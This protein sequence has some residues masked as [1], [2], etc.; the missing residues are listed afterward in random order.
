MRA[1]AIAENR[2]LKL[3]Q[4]RELPLEAG[5]VRVEVSYCGICGSDLHMLHLPGMPVGAI[6]GHEASGRVAEVGSD[7]HDWNVG[8][9]VVLFPYSPCGSC[10][11]CTA[12]HSHL[13]PD[14]M[15]RAIG[16]GV[17]P[18]A[19]AERVVVDSAMLEPL[20]DGLSDEAAALVEP[21]AVA[22]HG[23]RVVSIDNDDVPTVVL[24]AGPIGILTALTLRASG[25]QTR[26][27]E[28]NQARLAFAG[29]LGL[30]SSD[31]YDRHAAAPS[32]IFD[33][34]GH[35]AA[36][37]TALEL[38]SPRAEIVMLGIAF[39]PTPID[40]E[41]VVAK[42]LIIR[43]SLAY[44]RE[45]FEQARRMLS[46][47]SVDGSTLITEIAPLA[48]AEK[49]FTNLSSGNSTHLKVLLRP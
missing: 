26:V 45:D 4:H 20:P 1:I 10:S 18:G 44:G 28:P 31:S 6:M 19:Y 36:F 12:G 39:G 37:R 14:A 21:L 13:C 5:Q 34:T 35:P 22:V 38:A 47:G 24:G 30:E 40:M 15:V 16:L 23:V 46:D 25:I 42:E 29:G 27:L 43:G 17:R 48:Q 2:C 33:C 41:A 32:L 9:R 49:W 3:V 7:V 8:D 11:A